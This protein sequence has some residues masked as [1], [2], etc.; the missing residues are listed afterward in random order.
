MPMTRPPLAANLADRLHD[1]RKAGD[2]AGAQV[3]AVGEAAGHE[4]GVAA[5]Q[6]LRG[7]PEDT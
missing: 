7:M 5:L 2:R 3:V 1:R 4:D 6:I